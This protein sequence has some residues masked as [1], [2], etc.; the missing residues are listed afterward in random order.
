MPEMKITRKLLPFVQ[1]SKRFKIAIGG[2][3]SGKSMTIA[4]ICLMD[5]QTKLVKTA[6]FRE[7]QNSIDDSVHS[8]LSD[9][10]ERLELVGFDVQEKRLSYDG[11][12]LFKFK[13]LA[14]NSEGIKSMHGFKRF[15]VE[16][17]QTISYKSL[18]ALTPTL[19]EEGS[20]IWMTA[21]PQSSADPFSQRFI[22][23]YEKELLKNGY[24]EDDLHLIIVVN[25]SDNPFFPEVLQKEMAHDKRT[26]STAEFL[27]IWEG[28]YNDEV[29]GSIISVDWFNAAIDAHIKLGFAGKGALTATF[30]PS[31]E[32]GDAKGYCLRHG[33]VILDVAESQ[34]GDVNEGCDWATNKAMEANADYFVWDCDGLGVSLKRQIAQEFT[35]KKITEVMFKG[36]QKADRP[37]EN[38]QDGKS[39]EHTF[40]NKRAQYYWRLRDRF[41]NTYRAITKGEYIDP[42]ELISISSNIS[43]IDVLRAEVC[44]IPKKPNANGLIQIKSKI[45]MKAMGINSPNLADA[46][47][48]SMDIP[49]IIDDDFEMDYKSLW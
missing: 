16:E 15:W 39:N 7:Y 37:K 8:L 21:N 1:K 6:C 26:L 44:R 36:S 11:Q 13:G 46:L 35:D 34:M 19:R 24:Y 18:R 47:M 30:D 38:Y 17:A 29:A 45:E 22:K 3:G 4:D 48:M 41:Y 9:E 2:R 42:D 28:H 27:H 12:E 32:G 25:H 14:R 23:P 5:A 20:E 33:S 31:D 10:I 40:K 43:D 49:Y